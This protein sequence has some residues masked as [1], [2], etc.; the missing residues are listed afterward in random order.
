DGGDVD[1]LHRHH[2]REGTLCLTAASRKRIGQ[3]ARR[4]MPGATRA[5][6]A[7]PALACRPAIAHDRVPV[8]VRL[9]LSVRRDLEGKGLAVPERRAAV[10]TETGNAENV[11]QHCQHIARLA[12]RVVTGRLVNSGHFTI[13][14]GSGV[15]M[16][17]LMR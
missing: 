4:D 13:R 5:V 9:F 2:R 7:P 14:K 6:L 15:E 16:R 17:R 11:E 8:A 3:R 10:E 12:A 1:L